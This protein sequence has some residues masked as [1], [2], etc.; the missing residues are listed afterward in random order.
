VP[1][2][3]V[4][5]GGE[6]A[7]GGLGGITLTPMAEPNG[8]EEG[9]SPRRLV[10]FGEEIV[11][12][13]PIVELLAEVERRLESL[14]ARYGGSVPPAKRFEVLDSALDDLDTALERVRGARSTLARIELRLAAAYERA[15]AE[16][17]A[18]EPH[19]GPRPD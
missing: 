6:D 9:K 13:P 17:R 11:L 16:L 12:D 3:P 19:I 7:L 1:T 18:V 15:L 14:A 10:L 5:R 4:P 2:R 8:L